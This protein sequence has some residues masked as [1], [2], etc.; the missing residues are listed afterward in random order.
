LD[1]CI[2]TAGLVHSY[3]NEDFFKVNAEGSKYLLLNLKKRYPSAF[4]FLLISSLSC[5]G[6]VSLGEKKDEEQIDFPVSDYGRSKKVSEN[7]LK[8][9]A[10]KSWHC[11]IVR[12]PMIIGPGDVAVLDIFKMVKSRVIILPGLKSKSKE[13]SFVC[14]FDLLETITK[15]FSSEHSL[16]LYS[17]YPKT[18][19]F[20]ELIEE[21]KLQM[22]ISWIFYL[23]IPIFIVKFMSRLLYFI[24]RLKK[25][26]LRLTP[27]K[28]HEL[29]PM[30][31]CCD[32]TL[33]QKKLSQTYQFDLAKTVKIT[34][35]DYKERHWI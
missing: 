19:E 27:D 6:P 3:T 7:Y 24:Y 17:A 23:P 13:Y 1:G 4:K 25:H 22:K 28:I 9:L 34:L 31:W 2:H 29:E 32:S 8:E 26:E 33:S 30:A 5:A 10:P 15:L 21:I 35:K 12:P 20:K 18:I 11:K 16:I 14:V